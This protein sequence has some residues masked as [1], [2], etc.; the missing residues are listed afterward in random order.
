[1]NLSGHV[2]RS[3]TLCF[4]TQGFHWE[5]KTNSY[6]LEQSF[7]TSHNKRIICCDVVAGLGSPTFSASLI[8]MFFSFIS[9]VRI[10]KCAP[11]NNK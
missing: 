7:L 4:K 10:W 2:L 3:G 5:G 8:H 1:M 9:I 6:H 11:R